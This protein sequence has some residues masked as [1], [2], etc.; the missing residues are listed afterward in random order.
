[1]NSI[2]KRDN[3]TS[4][5]LPLISDPTIKLWQIGKYLGVCQKIFR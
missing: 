3:Q 4:S 1:M 2:V 5:D